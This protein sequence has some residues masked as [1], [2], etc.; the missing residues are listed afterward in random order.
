MLA[1]I[2]RMAFAQ[3]HAPLRP[4]DEESRLRAYRVA[5]AYLYS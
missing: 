1:R 3:N 2:R 4:I 5:S